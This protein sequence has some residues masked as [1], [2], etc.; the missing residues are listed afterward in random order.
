MKK[1]WRKVLSITLAGL[2]MFS[3]T[4]CFGNREEENNGLAVEEAMNNENAKLAVFKEVGAIETDCDWFQYLGYH[5]DELMALQVTYRY[6]YEDEGAYNDVQGD[7]IFEDVEMTPAVNDVFIPAEPGS[8]EE[9]PEGE[10]TEGEPYEFWYDI[11]VL[12]APWMGE[13]KEVGYFSLD[14]GEY[15]SSVT[16]DESTGNII[17][18]TEKSEDDMTDPNMPVWTQY[19]Y[20]NVYSAAGELLARS[21]IKKIDENDDYYFLVGIAADSSGNIYL[22][23]ETVIDIYD[24]D[25]KLTG[26]IK[27]EG[28]DYASD[29]FV[30]DDGIVYACVWSEGPEYDMPYYRQV[31]Q[32]Q[33]NLGSEIPGPENMWGN[34]GIAPGHDF[35]YDNDRG[36]YAYDFD[37]QESIQIVD[38]LESDIDFYNYN[39]TIPVSETRMIGV[40]YNDDYTMNFVFL[41]K[42]PPEQVVDKEIITLGMMYAS[43]NVRSEVVAFN[44]ANDQYRIRIIDYSDYYTEEEPEAGVTM[45]NNDIISGKAPDIILIDTEMPVQSYMEKGVFYNLNEFLETDPEVS[46]EDMAANLIALG[47]IGEDTYIL[48]ASF[49]IGTYTMK[50]SLTSGNGSIT[51]EDLQRL[52]SQ[53]NCLALQEFTKAD[54]LSMALEMSSDRFLDLE[55]GVCNFHSPE[56][57]AILEYANKYPEE[58]NYDSMDSEYWMNY[59]TAF[60]ENRA[61]LNYQHLSGFSYIAED[62]QGRFG[63]KMAFV[64][65]P[66]SGGS[67]IYPYSRFAISANSN[68]PEAAWEYIRQYFTYEY[69]TESDYMYGFPANLKAME[70]AMQK[71]TEPFYYYDENGNKVEE[72]RY[73]YIGDQ[74]ILIEPLTQERVKEVQDFV[75]SIEKEHYYNAEIMSIITEEAAAYFAGQKTAQQAADII[76]S[77]V[78]IYVKE[79]M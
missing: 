65:F 53:Y 69:Q 16:V 23:S 63:E 5:N 19:Y 49:G 32:D 22:A 73:Y 34:P 50:E 44:K 74:Q 9:E 67:C 29:I 55:E 11:S 41:E 68:H 64:G 6:N 58:I 57:C 60:R 59:E 46:K 7:V 36:V 25:L 14:A 47:S 45:L 38:F 27:M 72:D 20:L 31:L 42:V 18:V 1:K 56:F 39:C 8:P 3:L 71:A 70:A 17:A 30:T 10:P 54:I 61:L 77:R 4:G 79:N 62:E 66:G 26:S 75:L 43:F 15:L 40:T 13:L 35:Y 78:D 24:K 76:Q 21:E 52:E 28:D 33:R 51:L 37:T 2:M 48:S 12:K